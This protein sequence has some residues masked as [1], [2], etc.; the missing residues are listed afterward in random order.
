VAVFPDR[1]V[2]KNSTDSQATIEAAIQTGGTD[3]ITQGEIVLGVDS[4]DVAIYTKAGDGSIIRFAPGAAAGRAIVSDTEPTVGINGNPLTD[5]D[6]WYESDTGSYYVYYLGTWVEVSGGGGG[7]VTSVAV[8]GGTGLTSSGGPITDAGTITVD[9]DDTT[10]TP[11]SYTNA[12]ITVDAQGRITAAANGTGGGA[13]SI[14]D[15]TDVDTTTTPP[16]NDQAL[17]WNGTT[18]VPGDVTTGGGGSVDSVNG[19]TGVVSLGIDDLTDVATDGTEAGWVLNFEYP[20]G[21][22]SGVSNEGIISYSDFNWNSC[23]ISTDVAKFGS[24]S[25]DLRNGFSFLKA[26][27]NFTT[28]EE[29]SLAFGTGDFTVEA[30]VYWATAVSGS[31]HVVW[32]YNNSTVAIGHYLHWDAVNG[33]FK[34]RIQG[35]SSQASSVVTLADATWHHLAVTRS[36][37]T[38]QL[39]VNGTSVLSYTD[40]G[41]I[42][43]SSKSLLLGGG[44]NAGQ[45]L[46]GYMDGFRLVKGTALYTSDFT[47]PTTPPESFTALPADGQVLTWVDAN[48]RW[49]PA[50]ATS[51]SGGATEL[52]DLTDVGTIS[53]GSTAILWD[54]YNSLLGAN[55]RWYV[56][57]DQLQFN[58]YDDQFVDQSATIDAS[59]ASG[60]LLISQDGTNYSPYEYTSYQNGASADWRYF[61]LVDASGITQSGNI[62]I[63]F[64]ATGPSDGQVLTW[65][66]ANN[67][68]EPVDPASGGGTDFGDVSPYTP[69]LATYATRQSFNTQPPTDEWSANTTPSLIFPPLAGNGF[70]LTDEFGSTNPGT[71][72]VSDDG[73]T[74]TYY[75]CSNWENFSTYFRATLTGFDAEAFYNVGDRPIWIDFGPETNPAEGTTL[76]YEADGNFFKIK[77]NSIANQADFDYQRNVSTY[78]FTFSSS[79]TP[80][81]ASGESTVWSSYTAGVYLFL[82]TTDANSLDAETDLYALT[83]GSAVAMSVNGTVVF[84]GNLVTTLNE[85]SNRIT[86]QF[87]AVQSWITSLQ[88]GDVVGIRSDSVFARQAAPL[89]ITDGQVLTWV[90]ANSQWEPADATGGGATVL[91][92]LDDVSTETPGTAT[93]EGTWTVSTLVLGE[94]MTADGNMGPA[95]SNEINLYINDNSGTSYAAELSALNGS[96]FYWRKNSEPWQSETM[97]SYRA[98]QVNTLIPKA[99][100]L[101]ASVNAAQLGDTYTLADGSPDTVPTDGQVLTWVDANN[102]W[103]AVDTLPDLITSV[104]GETG[105]VSLS[106]SDLDN[107]ASTTPLRYET[108]PEGTGGFNFNGGYFQLGNVDSDGNTLSVSDFSGGTIWISTNGDPIQAVPYSNVSQLSDFVQFQ[109]DS[110]TYVF[111]KTAPCLVYLSDPAG[112]VPADGQVLTWVQANDQWEARDLQGTAIRAALGIG[113]YVDDAAA[114]TGGVASGAMYY[115][116]TSGDYRLKS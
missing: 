62:Y 38:V 115:N 93:W 64:G 15:L 37:S 41:N 45:N 116:T 32:E 46:G 106:V 105:E 8:A 102:Q 63:K 74:F 3:E 7:G 89:P 81:P 61:D 12:D 79:D 60:V 54:D 30:W 9:L 13:T 51:G 17:I 1:I 52:D 66:D 59:P 28:T 91:N 80:N 19:Q 103:E 84:D 87:S 24:G 88:A 25:V 77:E 14:G 49:E 16:T 18:W 50:D 69:K 113:E 22:S 78:E 95:S 90:D 11:G 70:N 2:L 104:N 26:G 57:G 6:L 55:G 101:S 67:Q 5:G 48:N 72:G 96:T 82:S 53:G 99:A 92:D 112:A 97:T 65:V 39:F 110:A 21:T 34:V 100:G 94:I 27:N 58:K 40:G 107:V 42:T 75:T 73:H 98:F 43:G 4:T 86:L 35:G 20:D 36:S 10:V 47:P 56:S 33:T 23:D 71:I 108:L 76:V 109:Y 85:N 44:R 29:D 114:G 83:S 68:W 31:L 111:T